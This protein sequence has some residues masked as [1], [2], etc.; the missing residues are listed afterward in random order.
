[1]SKKIL[2]G[3]VAII[4][5]ISLTGCGK[6]EEKVEEQGRFKQQSKREVINWPSETLME[7]LDCILIS[8]KDTSEGSLVEV[9]WND[10]D[11]AKK[12]VETLI[13]IGEEKIEE[14]EDENTYTFKSKSI[15]IN[16]SLNGANTILIYK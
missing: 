6:K 11:S 16:Y 14:K 13:S 15:L 8:V 3:V 7:P 2:L 1:M 9:E 10:K 12:Y 4:L 5:C